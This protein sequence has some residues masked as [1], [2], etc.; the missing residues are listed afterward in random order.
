[1]TLSKVVNVTSNWGIKRPRLE[2]PGTHVV[3]QQNPYGQ[4]GQC[5]CP[6]LRASKYR[7]PPLHMGRGSW[8]MGCFRGGL[9]YQTGTPLGGYVVFSNLA[10]TT[11]MIS[12]C[13]LVFKSLKS[14]HKPNLLNWLLCI[15]CAIPNK[16]QQVGYVMLFSHDGPLFVAETLLTSLHSQKAN[17]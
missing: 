10:I 11:T 4:Y 6:P 16:S 2:S 5:R 9:L 13:K 14:K 12:S 8:V 1:M 7:C 3:D 15:Y 17:G